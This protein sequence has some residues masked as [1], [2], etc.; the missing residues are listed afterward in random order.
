[1]GTYRG[2]GRG[3]EFVLTVAA[4]SSGLTA[5]VGEA[6]PFPLRYVDGFTFAQGATRFTFVLD[7][8]VVDRLLVDQIGGFYVL[9]PDQR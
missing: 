3:A 4:D 2:P 7:A 1:V 5:A 9:R 6:E 8:G